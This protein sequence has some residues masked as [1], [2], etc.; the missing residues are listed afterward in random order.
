MENYN[1]PSFDIV[2][3][4]KRESSQVENNDAAAGYTVISRRERQCRT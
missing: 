4:M 1:L 2:C 3:K